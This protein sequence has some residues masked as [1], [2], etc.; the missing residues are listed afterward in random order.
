MAPRD[1][2]IKA[3]T[4]D[5]AAGGILRI[6]EG[7]SKHER[8]IYFHGWCGLGA[9][10]TLRMVAQRLKSSAAEEMKF[11]KVVHVDCSLW[12]GMRALQK[13]IVEE[14][15]LPQSVMAIFDQHDEE[16]DF[17]GIDQGSRGV[18][19][20]VTEEI[21]RKLVNST[22]VVIFHN[23][24]GHYIDLYQCG[25]PV[26][27]FLSNKVLWTWGR[28]LRLIDRSDVDEVHKTPTEADI[29]VRGL[30][31]MGNIL[32]EE[33]AEVAKY[34]GILEPDRI[35]EC[36]QYIWARRRVS[37]IDWETH[38]SNYW[39]CD[40]IIQEQDNISRWKVG[41]ALHRFIHLDW[42]KEVDNPYRKARGL[43]T[44]QKKEDNPYANWI[45][46][47][48]SSSNDRW[49]SAT[50]QALLHDIDVLPP[51]AT[52]FFLLAGGKVILPAGIFQNNN[53][54][55]VLHLSWC[56][57][58]FTLPPFL[59]CSHLR[60][61]LLDHCTDVKEEE[62]QISN[63]NGSCFQKL[64]VLDLRN[65]EW[66]S[67][68]M[69]CLMDEL[70]E[71]NVDGVKDWMRIVELCGSRDRLVKLRVAAS[72]DYVT[73]IIM[74]QPAPNI[75]NASH[76]KTIIL[77][78]CVGLEQVVPEVLPPL[79]ESFSFI[80][81]NVAIPK[82][83]SISFPG[84][85]KL[86][87][88][89]L[90][91]VMK[92][93]QELDLSGTSIKTLDL[94]E[95]VALNLKRII[96]LGCEKLQAI[97]WPPPIKMAILEMMH[98]ETIR[99]RS[100][101]GHANWEEKAKE[102]SAATGSSCIVAIAA[103]SPA[104][105]F[106]CYISV[107]DARLLRSLRPVIVCF[108]C[109]RGVR[110]PFTLLDIDFSTMSEEDSDL[111]G[112]IEIA[113]VHA[114]SIVVGDSGCGQGIRQLDH[115]LYERDITFQ[116][117]LHAVAANEGAI[118]SMWASPPAVVAEELTGWYIRIQD[119]EE[120]RSELLQNQSR[121]QGTS[122]LIPGYICDRAKKLH[123]HDSLSITSIPFPYVM[124]FPY[125]F[126]DW[127]S[128]VRQSW[129]HLGWCQIERCPNLSSVFATPTLDGDEESHSNGFEC[130]RQLNTFW[131]SQL[132]KARFIWMCSTMFL[133]NNNSFQ[134]LTF[135]HLDYCPRLIHVLPLSAHMTTLPQL[136]TLEI[137]CCGDLMEIFPLDP[138]RQKKQTIIYF[139]KLKRIH[140]HDLPR[141]QCI[142]GSKMLAPKLKTI[143]IRGCW[144]LKHLPAVAKQYPEVDC[145][146]DWWD[147]LEW[148]EGDANHHPS[149][150]KPRHSR[151]YK[152]AQL[153][154]GT[155]L[156]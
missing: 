13:A 98:I 110:G 130:F 113:Y 145:E 123:V 51:Q 127:R 57:F 104:P 31:F 120:M 19:L 74:H 10:A 96:L 46:S 36:L 108:N 128:I 111:G 15:E 7:A 53:R 22:F 25:V 126:I 62:H 103:T 147:N 146:S 129:S 39:V 150:Y 73:E 54:L 139:P 18:I 76:L 118:C 11:D 79:L 14:L 82:I 112:H 41:D 3:N 101:S 91:G 87:S 45:D 34:I 83:S 20:E 156:R 78:N 30:E 140:L 12:Q 71:L 66:Y 135:L 60:F 33:A 107:R 132:L 63:Q 149:L 97:Q 151:Y 2:K 24:S 35:V 29:V 80:I 138:E 133:P 90:R 52:S 50:H 44:Y 61:L 116:D 8:N 23:G 17:D 95:V 72:P 70:R 137:V 67:N 155:I 32:H 65:T 114:N 102:T 148:D 115:Y 28:R 153:P 59:C 55:R 100:T 6:L 68:T 94:R 144:S 27:I 134:N 89:L 4:I 124:V 131:A 21:F 117:H 58:S 77:E 64:W 99:S 92:N 56:T 119:E 40:G 9:S 143:K 93:L 136:A 38:A 84:R 5:D 141:L 109:C 26:T 122:A 16:D 88:M 75:S 69:L 49:V 85:A 42:M 154:R 37:R 142:C 47:S 106:D 43:R 125:D 86:K 152:K 121:T 48:L 81:T 105:T 1:I